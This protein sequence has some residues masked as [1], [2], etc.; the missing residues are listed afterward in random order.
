MIMRAAYDET[1]WEDFFER[2]RSE[3]IFQI[4]LNVLD[5]LLCLFDLREEFPET[6]ANID[7][8]RNLIEITDPEERAGLIT[9]TGLSVRNKRWALA[10][11]SSGSVY[12]FFWWMTSLPFK[13]QVYRHKGPGIFRDGKD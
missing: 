5:L 11:Y 10:L 7:E 4:S 6:A 1:R 3:G 8:N 2:R 13:L 12:S 9:R